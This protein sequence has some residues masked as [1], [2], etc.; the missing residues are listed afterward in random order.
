MVITDEML[1]QN[2]E[3]AR[4][5][6]LATF[7]GKDDIPEYVC[8]ENFE[9][10]MSEMLHQQ[11]SSKTGRSLRDSAK[12][13][14][15]H[16]G[17]RQVAAIL[18]AVLLI[19]S[20]VI[21]SSPTARAS[22]FNWVH[23]VFEDYEVFLFHGGNDQTSVIP[24]YQPTWL[25]E[26]FTVMESFRDTAQCFAYYQGETPQDG[27]SYSCIC[28]ENTSASMTPQGYYTKESVK[29]NGIEGWYYSAGEHLKDGCIIW[30]DETSNVVFSVDG[31]L[32][33]N[34]LL[35]IARGISISPD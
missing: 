19:G 15:R 17:L 35:R 13:G 25:P 20:V 29:I 11:H 21:I 28:L 14:L 24:N 31:T 10:Q 18:L 32:D 26:G 3:H 2:A 33:K 12:S 6:W 34:T 22:V 8:S 4:E 30:I 9:L 23:E 27:F 16:R 1:Y 5:L 7:P